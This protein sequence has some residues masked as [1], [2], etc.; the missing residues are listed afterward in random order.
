MGRDKRRERGR[1]PPFVMLLKETLDTPAWRA[2]SHGARSLH[3]AIKRRYSDR[4]H[5]NGHL[6]VSLREAAQELDS[7]R[8]Q[9]ARWFRELEHY[10]FIVMTEAGCL[11]VNGKGKAPHWRLTEIG[12]MGN[13]ADARLPSLERGAFRGSA[14]NKIPARKTGSG[15]PGN[16]GHFW[17]QV[18]RK[19]GPYSPQWVARK[20]GPFLD[21]SSV[22]GAFVCCTMRTKPAV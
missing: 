11:G 16:Q 7:H 6:H 8:D 4:L 22:E 9:C 12:Y 13:S 17:E 19:T 3:V 21:P 1:S 5:N 10:G 15:W 20:S 18:A 14:K 2:M